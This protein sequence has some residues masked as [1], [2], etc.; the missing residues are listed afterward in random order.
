[1]ALSQGI[2]NFYA[3]SITIIVLKPCACKVLFYL[4]LDYYNLC[5]NK[6]FFVHSY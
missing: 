1:M 4:T 5:W 2:S 3:I 6:T